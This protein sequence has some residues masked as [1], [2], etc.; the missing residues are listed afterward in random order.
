MGRANSAAEVGDERLASFINGL[1]K[2]ELHLHIEGTLEPELLFKI[3]ARNGVDPGYP[4]VDALKAAYNFSNLQSFLDLYFAGCR[5]LQTEEDFFDLTWA[6]LSKAHSQGVVHAEIM[7]DP[8]THLLRGISFDTFLS[9]I[10]RAVDKAQSDLGMSSKLL[11]C[12][13]RNLGGE[14]AMDTLVQALPYKD[15][16]V[17]VGLDSTEVPYPPSLFTAV[18]DKAREE[19][20]LTIS[21]A[22]EEGPAAYIWEAVNLLHVAR[23]DHGVKCLEDP[24]L[25]EHLKKAKTPLT[26]CPMSNLKLKVYSGMLE[27][28]MQELLSKD[29][30]ITLNSDDPAYFGGYLAENYRYMASVCNLGISELGQLAKNSFIAS[31]IPDDEKAEHIASVEQYVSAFP[32]VSEVHG[33]VQLAV[34]ATVEA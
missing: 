22:G 24:E 14:A 32:T 21:H 33:E 17:A 26:V 11:L 1:P 30:V 10:R 19:G 8:Q 13:L 34:D 5:V 6:Y 18:F 16:F 3:A 15:Y 4:S 20:L 27:E 25:L 9:G 23:I 28:K 2:A 29:L 12:F 7:F 31:F